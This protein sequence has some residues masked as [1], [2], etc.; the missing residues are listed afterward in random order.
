MT[1]RELE[2]LVQKNIAY[3]PNMTFLL[4]IHPLVPYQRVVEIVDLVRKL[5]VENF[6]FVM[7][8]EGP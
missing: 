5:K 1:L 4:T 3:Y 6:S 7:K 8:G 2:D